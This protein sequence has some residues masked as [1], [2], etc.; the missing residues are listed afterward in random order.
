MLDDG[1][2]TARVR[3]S[4]A[5][6][7]H[8]AA[9]F[10]SLFLGALLLLY[11]VAVRTYT[12]QVADV[13][14]Y[15]WSHVLNHGGGLSGAVRS[16]LHIPLLLI[17]L[18]LVVLALRARDWRRLAA[19]LT[20]AAATPVASH[21]LRDVVFDRPYLGDHDFLMNTLP[22]GHVSLSAALAVAIVILWPSR[23]R[24]PIGAAA[25]VV[26]AAS[27]ASVVAH[28]HRP[29]DVLASVLLT[30][31]ITCTAMALGGPLAAPRGMR[32][33][34][35]VPPADSSPLPP[36]R[37]SRDWFRRADSARST[38]RRRHPRHARQSPDRSGTRSSGRQ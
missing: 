25:V 20:V 27:L 24:W 12:G 36:A 14:L 23:A 7:R 18:V 13:T 21:W 32:R 30:G 5:R 28:A 34:M 19:G 31:A 2:N 22:S 29:S 1:R 26:T 38:A 8:R 15:R 16:N 3:P 4:A 10:S 9:A 11:A 35:V 37:S 33:A 17:C 6:F